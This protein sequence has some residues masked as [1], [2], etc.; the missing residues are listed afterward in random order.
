MLIVKCG[1]EKLSKIDGFFARNCSIYDIVR[2]MKTWTLRYA[3]INI[4]YF[5]A[6]C[7]VHAFAAVFLLDA[8]FSNTLV[9]IDLALANIL[10]VIIQPVIAG[11][12]DKQGRLTN[13]NV[14][15]AASVFIG[16][17]AV[18]LL[19]AKNSIVTV[20]IV[21]AL[22]YMVQMAYQPLLI[23]MNFEYEKAGCNI[24]F[25]LAR[26][27]GSAGFA[28]TSAFTGQLVEDNGTKVLLFG[29][30]ILMVISFILLLFFKKPETKENES[31]KTS[32]TE[33]IHN[34]FFDFARTYPKF[35][36]LLL[37]CILFF[38][39]HNSINDY[40]IQIIRPLGGDE[41]SLGMATFLA[42]I[43]ELPT[44]AL[45]GIMLKKFSCNFLIQISGVF[46]LIKTLLMF[47]AVNMSGV[48][49]SQFMQIGAYAV[50]IP[51][52]AYFVDMCLSEHDKVKGQAYI[53]CAITLSGVFSN[54]LCGRIL[55]VYGKG[56]MLMLGCIVSA[57]GVV[58]TVMATKK[59]KITD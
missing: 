31:E 20:F 12:I 22:I 6:F 9:G 36:L 43:L 42:A 4:T 8:G 32:V 53:N 41:S 13:R 1:N 5:A 59:T 33:D 55:D 34:N 25:G 48:F 45:I 26:G 35:M 39:A 2:F 16:V 47:L 15:M 3:L 58:I 50:Y 19:F 27:L 56:T 38:F 17:S 10:S 28:V 30:I 21:F 51:A 23:A 29:I 44:M 7:L 18:I 52:S 46:F 24:F 14:S 49:L 37:G 40:L 54:L 57:I 11:L